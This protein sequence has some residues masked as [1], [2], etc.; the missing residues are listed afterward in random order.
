VTWDQ[1]IIAL[2]ASVTGGNRY[3]FA[4]LQVHKSST[5]LRIYSKYLKVFACDNAHDAMPCRLCFRRHNAQLVPYQA[6][7]QR[8]LANVRAAN[9]GHKPCSK[10]L[11]TLSVHQL[12]KGSII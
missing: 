10:P 5:E 2:K 7:H 6:V 8:A 1:L 9:N 12:C 4:A 3:S 11:F